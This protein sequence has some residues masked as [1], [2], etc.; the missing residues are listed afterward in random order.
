MQGR[1]RLGSLLKGTS[2][3]IMFAER[4]GNCTNTG[5]PVYTTLWCD[6]TNYWRPAFCTNSPDRTPASPGHPA[7]SMFQVAPNWSSECDT[8]RAQSPHMAGM[9]V[10]AA[11]GGVTFLSGDMDPTVWANACDP[12]SGVVEGNWR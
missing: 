4:Y 3:T 11:D 7:C 9:T 1:N 2:H 10:G 6:A 12:A 5:T 8:S